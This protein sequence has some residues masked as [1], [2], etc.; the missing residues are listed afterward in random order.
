MKRK[1]Q[2]VVY[3]TN[4]FWGKKYHANKNQGIVSLSPEGFVMKR[5]VFSF[6][7]KSFSELEDMALAEARKMGIKFVDG[8]DE[9]LLGKSVDVAFSIVKKTFSIGKRGIRFATLFL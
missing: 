1:N 6:E 5:K 2:I 4:G 8:L 9:R 3:Y 7:G